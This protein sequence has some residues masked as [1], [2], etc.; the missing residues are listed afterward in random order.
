[1]SQLKGITVALLMAASGVAGAAS[2]ATIR[3]A[4]YDD[5]QAL[6][7][8][9][10]FAPISGA[11]V[12]LFRD[13]AQ[14]ASA[15]TNAAGAYAFDVTQ[16]GD[17]DVVVDSKT[18]RDGV[19]LEQTFGPAGAQCAQPDGTT[20]TNNFRSSC[21]GG[22]RAA[23]SDDASTFDGAEHVAVIHVDGS[24]VANV[25]FAF[26]ANVVSNTADGANIQGSLR[27]FVM[28]ANAIHGPNVMRFAPVAKPG[29][30]ITV[31]VGV[32][33]RWWKIEL[34]TPLPELSDGGT[35]L[36]GTARS[37]IEPATAIDLNYGPIGAA[38]AP[39]GIARVIAAQLKPELEIVAG[40]EE[41]IVCRASCAIR[42]LAFRGPA[43][44]LVMHDDARIE[45]VMIGVRP[46][47][48]IVTPATVGLQIESGT[49]TARYVYV[50]AQRTAGIA[51]VGSGKLDAERISTVHC[52][53]PAAGSG[54]ALLTDGSI[55]RAS[56]IRQNDGAGIVIGTPESNAPA[57]N[58]T[59]EGST[60]SG[61]VA[62]VV[63]APGASNNAILRNALMW[64]RIG[65][66][67]ALP[68]T[69]DAAALANRIS[70][71]DYNEN[72]GRPIVLHV[73]SDTNALAE[74]AGSCDRMDKAANHGIAPPRIT[75]VRLEQDGVN[76]R[77][78][79]SGRACA[80]TN[81]EIY[82]S[83]VTT[84]VREMTER[85]MRLVR[86]NKNNPRETVQMQE[87][88]FGGAPSIGEFNFAGTTVANQ[89]G[90]FELVVP[91]R[92]VKND[93]PDEVPED[94]IGFHAWHREVLVG[95][96][97]TESA[98]SAVSIDAEGNTS[99]L[100]ARR[101]VG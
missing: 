59:I 11:S 24:D 20:R 14:F 16:K 45:N 85:E 7:L 93:T 42:A 58:N 27:Q 68:A 44:S 86:S 48:S 37:F 17:Y 66:I 71:N 15:R 52:G 100:S 23:V 18:L 50:G 80:G 53:T 47:L 89:D 79:I 51:V 26:S 62:G 40:G 61:N 10:N 30:T 96:D 64:N 54:V 5:P 97:P 83:Y 72:G 25:D 28:N 65:G 9:S 81:V 33:P 101:P 6:A 3:G 49:T 46:D 78:I 63:L 2:A 99:E 82:R 38:E 73:G 57:R 12:K 90:T 67:V 60:I 74:G 69:N 70:A 4:V 32:P 21:I 77:F 75:K 92:R 56:A 34:L 22:R 87:H 35:E 8:P 19:W 41:G 98:F 36:D 13:G 1:M 88:E 94:L 91:F 29:E 76:D 31:Q 43:T 95:D 84:E 39:Q 55:V